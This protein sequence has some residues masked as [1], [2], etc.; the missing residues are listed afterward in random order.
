MEG[1]QNNGNTTQVGRGGA[2]WKK[3]GGKGKW[4]DWREL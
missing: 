3:D 1:E 2:L 4:T